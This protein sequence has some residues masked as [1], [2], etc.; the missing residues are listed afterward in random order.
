ML[1]ESPP[2]SYCH[3]AS[4]GA[5]STW[6]QAPWGRKADHGIS[7]PGAGATAFAGRFRICRRA[8]R[9]SSSGRRISRQRYGAISPFIDALSPLSA[10]APPPIP[11]SVTLSWCFLIRRLRAKLS[12][13]SYLSREDRI[14]QRC[15][16][17]KRA[18]CFG[19][20]DHARIFGNE[21]PTASFLHI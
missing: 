4:S 9:Y 10:C 13:P 18:R 21:P 11:F 19:E 3:I 6:R 1:R 20:A 16:R 2:L 17:P 14:P 15:E 8:D 5:A 12:W 7:L